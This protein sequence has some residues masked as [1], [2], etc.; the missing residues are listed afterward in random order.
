[1]HNMSNQLYNYISDLIIQ[2]FESNQIQSGERFNFYLENT[3]S[4]SLLFDAIKNNTLDN[5]E[6]FHYTHPDGGDTYKTFA[7]SINDTKVIVAA[8]NSASEDYFTML[9]N[10]VADQTDEFVDTAILILFSGKL[11]SLLGG[12]GSLAKEGMPLHYSI[13]R[14]K[15]IKEI[16]ECPSFTDLDKK[17]LN[18]ILDKKVKSVVEDNNSIFDFEEIITIIKKGNLEQT[19]L[20]NL[21]LFPHP[22][23]STKE[24]DIIKELNNNYTDFERF[25]NSF[26]NGDPIK[27]FDGEFSTEF[28][29]KLLKEG[30]SNTDYAI[31]QTQREKEKEKKPPVFIETECNN[32]S[33]KPWVKT[34]GGSTTQKRNINII[35][36]NP[37]LESEF[38]I[39]IKFD[40]NI[41]EKNL[42]FSKS[43]GL[44]VSSTGHKIIISGKDYDYTNL[45]Y[46]VEY[47]DPETKKNY[48]IKLLLLP[49]FP[50]ILANY[51]GSFL[52][53]FVQSNP[54]L[55]LGYTNPLIFDPKS[56]EVIEET[57]IENETF[58]C[59]VNQQLK[60]KL[61]SS[62]SQDELIEFSISQNN[63][64]IPI[65]VNFETKSPTTITGIDVWKTKRIKGK[66][67]RFHQENDTVKLI[68]DNEE[69]S[70][71]DEFRNN[72]LQEKQMMKSL[73][74][75][76]DLDDE[77]NL[78]PKLLQLSE[79]MRFHFDKLRNYFNLK[80]SLPSLA[81]QDDE[82]QVIAREYV[83][84]YM[85]ELSSLTE[86]RPLTDNQR[87]LFWLGVVKEKQGEEKIKFSPLHP[88]NVAYQLELNSIVDE[89]KVYDAILKKLNPINLVP[90]LE[91]ENDKIYIPIE[92]NHSPEWLYYS[93]H[94]NSEQATPKSF[95]ADL[96]RDKIKDFTTNFDFLFNL[97][98]QAPLKINVVNMGDCKEIVQ[99][100]F[101]FYKQYLTKNIE[102]RPQDL[103]PIEVSIY[104]SDKIVTKFE[105][106][107]FYDSAN[108]VEKN[109]QIDLKANIFSK[110]DLLN[111]FW[112]KVTFY[113]KK[114]D[115]DNLKYEYAH[116]AFYQFDINQTEISYD[117]MRLIKTGVSFN[118]LLADV[119]STPTTDSYRTGFGT[120]DLPDESSDLI[121]L[122][123]LMNSFVRVYAKTHP[124]EKDKAITTTID[125]SVRHQ[126]NLLYQD[127]QWVTYIDPKVDLDFFKENKDL[128]II[129]YSDQYS[130]SSG[131]DAITV[132]RKTGEYEFIV[133]EFLEK[134][135]VKFDPTIDCV[136]IINLFNAINGEWL[137]KL[138]KQ[139]NQF[140]REKLSLLSGVKTALTYLYH[141]DVI[142]VPISL[143]EILRISGNVGLNN[144]NGLLSAKNLGSKG[145]L[146]DDLLFI[147]LEN[148]NGEL[149]MHFYPIELKIGN[150]NIVK[151]GIEQG[152]STATLLRE[153]LRQE[154]FLCEFYK[155]F[156]AK[157][158]LANIKKLKIFNI[159][160]SQNWDLIL[161]NYRQKLLNN[162]FLISNR[163]DDSIGKFGVIHFGTNILSRRVKINEEF[164]Q[165]ELLENDG[166]NFLVKSIDD[167]V[168]L[169]HK[170]E[171]T[172]DK[173]KLFVKLFNKANENIYTA[174]PIEEEYIEK[175]P[176]ENVQYDDDDF[177][178]GDIVHEAEKEVKQVSTP[179]QNTQDGIKI[180]FGTDLN[181]N[182]NVIWEPNNTNKVM[183]TNTGIIGT[184]GTGKTQFTKSLITQL[185]ENSSNNIGEEKLGILIFDY[186]GDYV[187][188][189]FVKKTNARVLLPH[190]LPYNPLALDATVNSKPMLP[191][192][193]ANDIKE[194]IA[195]AFNLGNVQKQKLRDVIVEAYNSNGINKSDR[196]SWNLTAPTLGDVCD[197][198][199][200]Q[201][202]NAQ[203][204]LYAA[205]SNLSDFE[206]FESNAKKTQSLYSLI[207]G[208]VVINL[209]G[210]DESIQNLIVAITLD[211]F[212]TQ[213][214]RNGHS[215]I[216]GNLR[217]IRKMILVDEAD[218]FLSKNFNSIRKILKEGREFGVG[219]ILSTQF[220]SHFATGENEYSNY[221]LTWVIHRV[222]EIKM[223]EVDSL[224][225]L[226]NKLFKE[227]LIMTIKNLE[228]HRSIVN[229]AGSAPIH[230]KDKAFWELLDE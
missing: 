107:A 94:L 92:S 218:N 2:Y 119:S 93:L 15:I 173:E 197:L 34:D 143:E 208:V 175:G 126:L 184:M 133:K 105:E 45:F 202:N 190:K 188:E 219:T 88:L 29:N 222:N 42:K 136:Q 104:G 152:R 26:T 28:I 162:D 113:S 176:S 135:K 50:N 13:F 155:N 109:L 80:D 14:E 75:G 134:H 207:E 63:I 148:Y 223:K 149:L 125:F 78:I 212:Y 110:G 180:L 37:N 59:E 137:L 165:F 177:P 171:T 81:Y 49:L 48:K 24:G 145:S 127:A 27:I 216:N 139:N 86:N 163:F 144:E 47:Q 87:D 30:W 192:H 189:D 91:I 70:V 121:E 25:E 230:I 132:S 67:Y 129:H 172:V 39:A 191:L 38:S 161:N 201:E 71:R 68:F 157:I 124:Y 41:R 185:H 220:L 209:S 196:E 44:T 8:A 138:I 200:G 146:S 194:T 186:K 3:D 179:T 100:I 147:G 114:I 167:L 90:N 101:K 158:L 35:V 7:V 187:K 159:W 228:K 58:R 106:L 111:A 116:I 166:Y 118:G 217:Q 89:Q 65:A 108:D 82:L 206:I 33:I 56:E 17:L 99:G 84:A 128:V 225:S 1:M 141:P 9:R 11:D 102:K 226:D 5:S 131:Y 18:F 83:Q 60:L 142:W 221:I 43:T 20:K 79:N 95:V 72:L 54:H 151:K 73:D 23:L 160:D 76:W 205:I 40:K 36:F 178:F 10:K 204:S 193:T 16:S 150:N 156:F 229:L 168:N 195:N 211:A 32:L 22:E 130:N 169:F 123:C 53:K 215:V 154:T 203:D 181:N 224:F 19:D 64:N 96:V 140:P 115:K 69:R 153:N 103:L 55:Y 120:V 198:Y 122:A 4:I 31:I 182:T 77:N 214:Q 210:Y 85:V 199:L 98:K 21:G 66:S 52:I 57:L 164:M 62:M 51:E 12:S 170:S 183:H 213:M 227:N 61:D 117:D 46:Q 74:Y 6:D 112:D 174:D 97:S